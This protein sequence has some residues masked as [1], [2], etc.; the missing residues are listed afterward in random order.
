MVGDKEGT[1]AVNVGLY[2]GGAD[3]EKVK[4]GFVETRCGVGFSVRQKKVKEVSGKVWLW[5][6]VGYF[7]GVSHECVDEGW[8]SVKVSGASQGT[9]GVSHRFAQIVRVGGELTSLVIERDGDGDSGV[10]NVVDCLLY[11][12][13]NYEG[14]VKF[15]VRLCLFLWGPVIE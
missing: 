13:V 7:W 5:S 3:G 1:Q 4:R 9:E 10:E 11:A 12:F 15:L 8:V 2:V 6:I 14:V